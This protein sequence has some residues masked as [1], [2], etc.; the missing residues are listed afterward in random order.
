MQPEAHHH[1]ARVDEAGLPVHPPGQAVDGVLPLRLGQRRLIVVAVER[2]A[3]ILQAV[4]P[5][6]QG[7]APGEVAHLV[8]GIAVQYRAAGDL[9]GSDSATDLGDHGLLLAPADL[10]LLA[11]R[12][13]DGGWVRADHNGILHGYPEACR[14]W[15]APGRA[16]QNRRRRGAGVDPAAAVGPAGAHRSR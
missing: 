8:Q 7:G 4:R 9:I 11:R 15:H 6:N 16:G 13:R 12:R 1:R 3:T 10:E 5:G 14:I 2:V